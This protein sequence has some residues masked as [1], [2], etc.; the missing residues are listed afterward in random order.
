MVDGVDPV[1]GQLAKPPVYRPGYCPW[2]APCGSMFSTPTDMAKWL[3]FFLDQPLEAS[4]EQT[5]QELAGS[6][7]Y[8]LDPTTRREMYSMLMAQADGNTGIGAATF[9]AAFSHG[10]WTFNKLGCEEGYRS[11]ISFVP[12][13]GLGVF[14]AAA[15]TCDDYGDGDAVGFPILSRLIPP[16]GDILT[17]RLE[18][19]AA[20]ASTG[21]ADYDGRYCAAGETAMVISVNQ[22]SKELIITNGPQGDPRIQTGYPW[23]LLPL[24]SAQDQPVKDVFRI[25]M[26][27]E[28]APIKFPGCS[29]HQFPGVNLCP[30]SCFREMARGDGE[31]LHFN[32]DP[33]SGMV[34]GFQISGLGLTCSKFL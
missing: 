27:G 14:A 1:T 3:S 5:Q 32:R 25:Q 2:S 34:V 21:G 19:A 6:Y 23:Y 20:A 4:V 7:A 29:N 11:V 33:K 18:A 24:E 10:R 26:K 13:L 31:I 17:K 15:S 12:Q 16:L 22:T 28:F 30:M 8:V 9:E